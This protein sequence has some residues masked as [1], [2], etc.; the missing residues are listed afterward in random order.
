MNSR[1]TLILFLSVIMG[2]AVGQD[3][4]ES[5]KCQQLLS[6]LRQDIAWEKEDHYG[7]LLMGDDTKLSF[8]RAALG[9]EAQEV[10]V[11][12]RDSC[13]EVRGIGMAL[14]TQMNDRMSKEEHELMEAV[15]ASYETDSA[16]IVFN[17]GIVERWTVRDYTHF[18]YE[19]HYNGN[20]KKK[21]PHA[22][23]E[24]IEAQPKLILPNYRH[25]R[26]PHDS[27]LG[28]TSLVFNTNDHIVV[29]FSMTSKRKF[30]SQTNTLTPRMKNT[31]KRLSP[32][33]RIILEDIK[34]LMPDG[35]NRL[36]PNVMIQII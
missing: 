19:N 16:K 11:L 2:R 32:G 33:D 22:E 13:A 1:V 24:R 30:H 34:L 21:D 5:R 10:V 4:L 26:M 8:Y 29:S 31:I 25:G 28:L 9:C 23:I 3:T 20:L 17:Q 7:C 14:L 35:T 6:L 12:T 36:A 27:L 15:I 18:L